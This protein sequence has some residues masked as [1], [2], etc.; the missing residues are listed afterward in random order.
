M[1]GP[2]GQKD[3]LWIRRVET[4]LYSPAPSANLGWAEATLTSPLSIAACRYIIKTVLF[5]VKSTCLGDGLTSILEKIVNF[6]LVE[7]QNEHDDGWNAP[8]ATFTAK[9]R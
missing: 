6:F 8:W 7:I 4:L 9:S 2:G 3:G 5:S 1:H